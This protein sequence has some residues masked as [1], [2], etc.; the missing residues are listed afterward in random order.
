M[1]PAIHCFDKYGILCCPW[2]HEQIAVV[3]ERWGPGVLQ[4]FFSLAGRRKSQKERHFRETDFSRTVPLS[5][6]C[7]RR[8]ICFNFPL[9]SSM[10]TATY[11]G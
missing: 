10:R 4:E 8:T 2:F 5:A 7:T 3:E 9:K 6:P 11:I 1:V